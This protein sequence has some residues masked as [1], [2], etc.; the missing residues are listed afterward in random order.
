MNNS[1]ELLDEDVLHV[2]EDRRKVIQLE[3]TRSG[4]PAKFESGGASSQVLGRATIMCGPHGEKMLPT[5]I[6]KTGPR[7]VGNHAL[8]V[9]FAGTLVV[10]VERVKDIFDVSVLK[11][12]N[13]IEKEGKFEAVAVKIL[14]CNG[15]EWDKEHLRDRFADAIEAAK[16]KSGCY[17]CREVHYGLE[18]HVKGVNEPSF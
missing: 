11:I 13:I 14:E 9:V 1:L 2:D 7:A 16:K 4:R 15:G 8:F 17:H 6:K 18:M 5:Y 12:K 3:R 10:E